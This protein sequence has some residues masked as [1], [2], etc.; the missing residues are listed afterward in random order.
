MPPESHD[1]PLKI[2]VWLV[3]FRPWALSF[4]GSDGT[5]YAGRLEGSLSS[6]IGWLL[7]AC[8]FRLLNIHWLWLSC[9]GRSL[10]RFSGRTGT[11]DAAPA[12]TPRTALN[13][14]SCRST[15]STSSRRYSSSYNS[16]ST[17]KNDPCC[18]FHQ[19]C[20]WPHTHRLDS[21][22]ARRK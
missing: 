10:K 12:K 9:R 21:R 3:R 6:A 11:K 4:L 22:R 14:R 17:H 19:V 16:T 7:V 13:C 18:N 8:C 1:A 5:H 2:H 15:Q 20:P